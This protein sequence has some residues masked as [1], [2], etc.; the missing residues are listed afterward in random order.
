AW[1][2]CRV[3]R[4]RCAAMKKLLGWA[5]V[6]VGLVAPAARADVNG[7]VRDLGSRDP[8]LR[9][10]AAKQL[11]ELGPD[12]KE[13]VPALTKALKDED[14]FV[15]RFAAQAL[16]SVGP[17]APG[18]VSALSAALKDKDKRVVE[19]AASALGKMGEGG[20]KPLVE[21]IKDKNR[22]AMARRTAVESLG[23]IGPAA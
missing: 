20:V 13:A 3:M 6:V 12:A 15:R 16:G 14:V 4:A 18:A 8:D 11:G 22:P 7:L 9:R 17:E 2:I 19:A 5:V 21:L 1:V 23:K 10:Q